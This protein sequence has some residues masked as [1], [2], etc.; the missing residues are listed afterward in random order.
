MVTSRILVGSHQ[1]FGTTNYFCLKDKYGDS[2][3]L[4]NVGTTLRDYTV[5]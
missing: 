2:I 5:Q 4:R 3:F 1:H